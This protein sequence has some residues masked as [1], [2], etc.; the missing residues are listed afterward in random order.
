[1]FTARHLAGVELA[2]LKRRRRTVLEHGRA[3][4][5]RDGFVAWRSAHMP[6][7]PARE[8]TEVL[9]AIVGARHVDFG[10]THSTPE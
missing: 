10:V 8:L 9:D 2:R 7:E 3:A 1:M 6:A 5:G 4:G